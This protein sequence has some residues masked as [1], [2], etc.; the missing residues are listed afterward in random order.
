MKNITKWQHIVPQFYLKEFK[1]EKNLI[2]NY[3]ILNKKFGQ[4][5]GTRP[6]CAEYFYYGAETGVQDEI[7][8]IVEE[9]LQSFETPLSKIIPILKKSLIGNSEITPEEKHIISLLMSMLYIRNNTTRNKIKQSTSNLTL[10]VL[11]GIAN[12][13]G[14][15]RF[16]NDYERETG[17]II[18][19]SE[20][21]DFLKAMK[22]NHFK[23]EVN[24]APHINF[25]S[26][27]PNFANILNT[28]N[29]IIYISK[30]EDNFI[31]SD[32]PVISNNPKNWNTQFGVPILAKSYYFPLSPKIFI[33]TYY[34]S[35]STTKSIKR[36][37]LLSKN[38]TKIIND[39]NLVIASQSG[40]QLFAS[41]KIDI[42]KILK[43]RQ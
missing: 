9:F 17:R 37:N 11:K 41:Q 20:K 31:T 40:K 4:P 28:Q 35:Q 42:E 7:S 36:K 19:S 23:I 29:W 39:L 25:L 33:K 8:Q 30:I 6:L 38:D 13:K 21:K 2:E 1:N 34:N 32:T 22:E 16:F 15:E 43:H 3:D 14:E 24:N 26:K 10:E 5:K 12:V 27:I 18:S